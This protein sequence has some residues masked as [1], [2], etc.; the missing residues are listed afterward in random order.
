MQDA[1][2]N[3]RATAPFG[4]FA[5]DGPDAASTNVEDGIAHRNLNAPCYRRTPEPLHS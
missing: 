5:L 4:S 3:A 1:L 2:A